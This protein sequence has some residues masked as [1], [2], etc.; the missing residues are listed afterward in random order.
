[1]LTHFKKVRV[2]YKPTGCCWNKIWDD[3]IDCLRISMQSCIQKYTTHW[4]DS[5]GALPVYYVSQTMF[6]YFSV[7]DIDDAGVKFIWV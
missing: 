6:E 7:N 2:D 4:S 5:H 3:L 1:M